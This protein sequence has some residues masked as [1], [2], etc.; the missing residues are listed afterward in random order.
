MSY[1]NENEQDEP[2]GNPAEQ[3]QMADMLQYL[4]HG[5][6]AP[7]LK[8]IAS[9]GE[10]NN[11]WAADVENVQAFRTM[12]R[13]LLSVDS[14][15][16]DLMDEAL[17]AAYHDGNVTPEEAAKVETHLTRAHSSYKQYADVYQELEQ[18]VAPRFHT[19]E[20]ALADL[21]VE[22]KA[23]AT[24]PQAI[25][26]IDRLEAWLRPFFMPRWAMPAYSFALGVLV[27]TVVL[28]PSSPDTVV[29][30]PSMVAA[31]TDEGIAFSVDGEAVAPT[32]MLLP[33]GGNL[34][35]TWQAFEGIAHYRVEIYDAANERVFEA[36]DV[37]TNQITLD[38]TIAN[39][40]ETYTMSVIGSYNEGG[41]LPVATMMFK[42]VP[43]DTP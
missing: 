17:L 41:V 10:H 32:V 6:E 4:Q 11:A 26:L 28:F 20:R 27:M 24:E 29:F 43:M 2:M 3:M 39:T 34:K 12:T 8:S 35:L 16:A 13:E 36:A 1:P 18:R 42:R 15:D 40:D 14:E 23:Q 7:M 37:Q 33:A 9:Y 25:S 30:M 5:F 38:N 31:D 19:P 21:K 22:V